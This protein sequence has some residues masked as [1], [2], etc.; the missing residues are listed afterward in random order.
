MNYE[1][2]KDF[3][4]EN[5]SKITTELYG[6]H[7]NTE[8]ITNQNKSELLLNSILNIQPREISTKGDK[9]QQDIFKD[10]ID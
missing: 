9:S 7:K 6:L 5:Y 10:K 3:I 2:Y 8:I 1:E 4:N